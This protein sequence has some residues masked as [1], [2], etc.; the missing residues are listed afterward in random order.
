MQPEPGLEKKREGQRREGHDELKDDVPSE[1]E[2]H[3]SR[4]DG[5]SEAVEDD[6]ALGVTRSSDALADGREGGESA[7]DGLAISK[8]TSLSSDG[9]VAEGD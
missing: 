9:E 8:A 3:L 4:T 7:G 6:L 5:T 2:E 1:D